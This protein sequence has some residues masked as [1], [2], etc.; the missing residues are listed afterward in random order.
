MFVKSGKCAL[1]ILVHLYIS[2]SANPIDGLRILGIFPQTFRSHFTMNERLM[3]GLAARG[4]RVD[5]YSHYPL[6]EPMENYTDHSIRTPNITTY[7]NNLH[8]ERLLKWLG[9]VDMSLLLHRYA[10]QSFGLA[11]LQNFPNFNIFQPYT[12]SCYL[13]FGRRLNIP[14]VTVETLSSTDW[15]Y[16]S[17]GNPRN[18]ANVPSVYG[19]QASPMTFVERLKNFFM[20]YYVEYGYY[21]FVRDQNAL[22]K[23]YFGEDYPPVSELIKD[24]DLMLINYNHMLNGIKPLTPAVVP[25]GGLHI[26]ETN[27]KLSERTQK[28]LDGSENGF[29]YFSFGSMVRIET[30]P[31][32]MLEMFY[33]AF[34][35]IAPTRVLWKIVKPE[36]LPTGLPDNVLTESWLPQMEVLKHKNIRAFITHGGLMGTMEAIYNAVPMIGFPL[37][38]DQYMNVDL[39]KKKGVAIK[40]EWPNITRESFEFALFEVLNNPLY[41]KEAKKLSLSFRDVPMSPMDTAAYWI[42]FIARNGKR[43]LRSPLVDMPWWQASLLDVYA[44]FLVVTIVALY[45]IKIIVWLLIILMTKVKSYFN[46]T[47]RD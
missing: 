18:L 4:H 15:T 22:V 34:R 1:L 21:Y 47:K 41:K 45:T 11:Q 31:K 23:K 27:N 28:F 7:L 38:S 9:I 37:F 33:N 20:T 5:V 29:V 6:K 13:A 46:K 14:L 12:A 32:P 25:V 40:L 30:F 19:G 42:E 3:R 26:A 36:E 43:S 10:F 2:V 24:V 39:Y 17:M 16:A 35:K 44:A 8:Y